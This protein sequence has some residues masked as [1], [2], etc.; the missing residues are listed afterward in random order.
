MST[1]A[2]AGDAGR[3]VLHVATMESFADSYIQAHGQEVSQTV[4]NL[5]GTRSLSNHAGIG[6]SYRR[7]TEEAKFDVIFLDCTAGPLYGDSLFFYFV[8]F[9]KPGGYLVGHDY[10]WSPHAVNL[11]TGSSQLVA[12]VFHLAARFDLTLHLG[13]DSLY[14]LQKPDD[15][16][17]DTG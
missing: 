2:S 10:E 16:V 4:P 14:W 5:D 9:L 3:T 6:Y 15:L 11:Q 17:I 7:I 13:T 8:F 1:N 12:Y